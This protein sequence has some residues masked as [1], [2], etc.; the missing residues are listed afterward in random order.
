MEEGQLLG[1]FPVNVLHNLFHLAFGIWGIA[2]S[3]SFSGAKA[4]AQIGGIVY[5]LLAVLAFPLP[6]FF[7]LIPIYG[8]DVWLHALIGIVLAAV[9]FTARETRREA[10]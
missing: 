9:G 1:L 8:N 3:R 7:G 5:L 10:V 2:A 6:R 4:Y